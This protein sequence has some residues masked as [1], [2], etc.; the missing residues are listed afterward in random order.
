MLKGVS[1]AAEWEQKLPP[2]T[3]YFYYAYCTINDTHAVAL[4]I[5][6]EVL[7]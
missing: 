7:A 6:L 2:A 5:L 3:P 4:Y 1:P